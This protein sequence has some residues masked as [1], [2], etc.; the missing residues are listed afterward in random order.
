LIKQ[1]Q[2]NSS[3]YINKWLTNQAPAYNFSD[4][5][6][7]GQEIDS[8]WKDYLDNR[9]ANNDLF[10][11]PPINSNGNGG[12][13]IA[14]QKKSQDKEVFIKNHFLFR[15]ED[16]DFIRVYKGNTR[17]LGFLVPGYYRL[18]ILLKDDRYL[19]KDSIFI[20]RDGVNYYSIDPEELKPADSISRK[21]ADIIKMREL[22]NRGNT[23]GLDQIKE[24]FNSGF[25]DGSSFNNTIF[26]R[27]LDE[28]GS[29]IPFV[30]VTIKGTRFATLTDANGYYWMQ[31]PI[32][33]TLI[34]Q[35]VG[36]APTERTIRQG[37]IDAVLV[38]SESNL[39]EVVV[40]AYGVSRKQSL[41]GSVSA[42][43]GLAGKVPGVVIRGS[44]T[45][46]ASATPLII[47]DGIP[48]E[49]D[50]NDLDPALISSMT[51]MKADVARALYG[52]RSANGVLLIT[53]RKG[54][55][56]TLTADGANSQ[57]LNSL[58]RRFRDDAYWQPTLLTNAE[59]K[60]RFTATF[61]DDIT[62]WRTFAIAIADQ[63][64]TGYAE[65]LIR[66]FKP[67]S[68]N[69]SLP[70]FAI[71]GDSLNLIGKTLNYGSDSLRLTRRITVNDSL[72]KDGEIEFQDTFLDTVA[73]I[74][75]N[76]D[77]VRFL[78]EVQKEEGYFDGEERTIPVYKQGLVE[79]KG[80]FAALEGDTTIRLQ[81]DPS[82]GKVTLHAEASLLPILL[83]ETEKIRRYEYLCNEQLASKLK[84]LL[85]QKKIYKLLKM[86]FDKEKAILEI[87]TKLNNNKTGN[88]WG[89]WINNEPAAWISLHVV[90]ALVHAEKEG[91]KVN[92]PKAGIIDNLVFN[93]ENYRGRD[94][95][96][97][98]HLLQQ[99][100][101]KVNYKS[102]IDLLDKDV[103]GM[104]LYEH[105]RLIE[106]KQK[107]GIAVH[108]DSIVARAKHTLF[109][110]IY[111]GEEGYQFFDN[112]I[113]NTLLMYRIIKGSQGQETTLRKIRNYFLEKRKD[114]HWRNTY[115]S[116]LIL[117]TI[118]PDLLVNG[119]KP[120]PA[121]L[122]LSN[123]KGKVIT[124]FPYRKELTSTEPLV[125]SK[126]GDFPIYFTAFQQSWSKTPA[127]VAGSFTVHST[128]DKNEETSSALKAG[129][130]VN[131][132]VH[133]SVKGDADYV[134]IEIPI[135]AGCSYREKPQPHSN[136]EVHREYFKN[137]VSVFCGSLKQG[138]YTF[139][140]PLLAR[141]TGM[142]HL[143]P[144]KAEM[145]YFPV[146]YGREKMKKVSIR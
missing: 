1:K 110:N 19:I 93:M 38:R 29:P 57:S 61:P 23:Q 39:Q 136:N 131:F 60:V 103:A 12:L 76:S 4:L 21:L 18:L 72:I 119:E 127:A 138:S 53:T 50:L 141:Y 108:I 43:N 34:F 85:S 40:V 25:L 68:A 81:M 144:A 67:I 142:Y 126:E 125:I 111:W 24:S 13:R 73:Y 132:T 99:L 123:E 82:L 146:F 120:K 106:L 70:Q 128:F 102:Y 79:T 88:L 100:N 26:G 49:G 95:L 28:N 58:R 54:S 90:E 71:E 31:A 46:E 91:Y 117:E 77:S 27:L 80:V 9:S 36:F 44:Q 33:G 116:S 15:Y 87:I 5:V 65:G 112:A 133:V 69:L 130:L 96:L 42:I 145:M 20:R 94:K 35:S 8:L 56:E 137:K 105:L 92:M 89:W 75:S 86:D 104:A 124:S 41:T 7:T 45:G 37:A 55:P 52:A 129:E 83:N 143:N 114:G 109:G 17:D 6:L 14:I 101:A 98:L 22:S 66:S 122:S 30:T 32:K 74:V 16:T 51:T 63:R 107:V 59:G 47:I 48:Y 134:M 115:E 3:S 62:N 10:N 140:I 64:R 84:A 2:V 118:L 78:L 97:S 135:P 113:Q 139:T 11:N 121:T